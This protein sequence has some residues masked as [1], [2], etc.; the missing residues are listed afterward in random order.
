MGTFLL[1]ILFV[2]DTGGLVPQYVVPFHSKEECIIARDDERVTAS[3]P[4]SVL[5]C[6]ELKE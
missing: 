1:L 3:Y 2:T 6:V 4:G 5:M